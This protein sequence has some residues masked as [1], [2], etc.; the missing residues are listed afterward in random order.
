[1]TR[2]AEN[3]SR[4]IKAGG[5]KKLFVLHSVH[6]DKAYAKRLAGMIRRGEA[7]GCFGQQGPHYA[8]VVRH[9]W[10]DISTDDADFNRWAVYCF[11]KEN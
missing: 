6:D 11:P 8:R 5:N 2:R 1:M 4:W 7:A 3:G 9:N 10:H